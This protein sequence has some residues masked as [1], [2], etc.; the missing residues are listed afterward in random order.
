MTLRLE[1]HWL[2]D[3]WTVADGPDIHLFHLKAPRALGD[4]GLRHWNVSIGHAVSG[5]LENWRV[6]PDAFGPGPEGSFD[7]LTT[8]TGSVIAHGDGW[9]MLY[10]GTRRDERGLVQRIGL[11]ASDDLLTW[12]RLPDAVL[13]ADPRWYE[14]L[15]RDAWHDQAWRDPWL[16]RVPGDPHVHAY[17]TA[18]AN[19][20]DPRGRGVVGHAR[21]RDL[22]AWEV[23][24]PVTAPMGFGQMEVPQ[25]VEA[26]GRFHL[27]FSSDPGTRAAECGVEGTGT[28]VLSAASPLGPFEAGTLRTL[29]AGVRDETYAGKLVHLGDELRFLSWV[30]E[31]DHGS[32]RGELSPARPCTVGPD[33]DLR[34]AGVAAS[35]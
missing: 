7:D 29:D 2:W 17:L 12:S 26:G 35:R 3:F 32:F 27:L 15:D 16:F 23:L 31:D 25:L 9:R 28:F 4:P 1:N 34:V 20:G 5:D 22:V 11:A 18:R 14:E 13:E 24:P 21:S 10:T 30:G 33:D 8:W 19:A 6:L